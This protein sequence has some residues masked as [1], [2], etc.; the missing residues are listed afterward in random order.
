MLVA[1]DYRGYR[2]IK[3]SNCG[4]IYSEDSHG[5]PNCDSNTISFIWSDEDNEKS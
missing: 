2:L 5:C 3:C 1:I 4:E